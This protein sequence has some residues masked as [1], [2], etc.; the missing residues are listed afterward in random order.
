[1]TLPTLLRI[2]SLVEDIQILRACV[3]AAEAN[4][5]RTSS[6][7]WAPRLL[8]GYRLHAIEASDRACADKK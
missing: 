5:F 1:M 7:F 2:A 8:T 4:A 3:Q 6:G